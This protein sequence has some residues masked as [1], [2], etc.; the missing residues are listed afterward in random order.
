LVNACF[1]FYLKTI[2]PSNYDLIFS[3]DALQHIQIEKIIDE[4]KKF[5]K[6]KGAKYLLVGSYLKNNENK[7]ISNYFPINLTNHTKNI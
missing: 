5:S 6:T 7:I 1:R 3:K 2:L 4:L